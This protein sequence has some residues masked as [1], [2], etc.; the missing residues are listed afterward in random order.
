MIHI[1]VPRTKAYLFEEYLGHWGRDLAP[2]MQLHTYEE[3]PD[4]DEFEPGT[5]VFTN[6][7]ELEPPVLALAQALRDTLAGAGFP[8]LNDPRRVLFRRELL[9]SL[10]S[11]DINRFR[12]VSLDGDL[13]TLMYP[14]FVRRAGDHEGPLSPLLYSASELDRWIGKTLIWGIARHDVLVVEFLDTAD[15]AGLYRKYGAFILGGR[16]LPRSLNRGSHWMVKH[17]TT[18]FT[19]EFQQEELDYLEANPHEEVLLQVVEIAGVDY[20][21]IDYSLLDGQVQIWEIN[22]CP[23][24]GRGA[25]PP[26]MSMPEEIRAVRRRAKETFYDGFFKAWVAVDLET[27]GPP[28]PAP[29][30]DAQ[31]QLARESMEEFPA[32]WQRRE[33]FLL[34]RGLLQPFKPILQP[35]VERTVVPLLGRLT[36]R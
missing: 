19:M 16:I 30:T 22:V 18:D 29:F 10:H 33:R 6:L 31:R 8:I 4:R 3:L 32:V 36:R 12:A 15:S 21:R 35:L 5:W 24:I 11:R 28:V 20:G 1:L 23:T 7:D 14:V 34:L 26:R 9:E 13:E 17:G 25:R 2:R 27:E